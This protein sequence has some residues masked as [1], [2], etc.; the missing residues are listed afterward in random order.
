MGKPRDTKIAI[1]PSTTRKGTTLSTSAALDSPSVIDKLVSPPHASRA[2]TSAESENSHNIDNVSAVLDDSGSL[3]SFLDAT[4][5]KSRQIE[6][7]ETPNAA[8]PVNSPES[9]EYSSDDLDEDYVE[10]DND[11]I[12]KCKATTDARKIKKLLAEHAVRY[13]PSPD[14]KFAT[15]PINIR[16][17]DYDFSLDLSHIAIVEKTP[18]CGTE[19]ESAVEHLT[20]LSTLSGVFSDDVKM[21]TYFVAKIFPFSLKDDAKTWY[22]NLPPGSIKS[23]TDLRDVFFRKYFPASAQHAALQRIYNFDQEDGEKLPEAWARFCSLIRAQPDH[24]LEKHDLLDIFYSGLTIESRAYLDSCAG[25]VFRKRTPDDAEE[26]LAKI[27]RNHDD[28]STPEP[29]P[30]PIV[31]KRG[32]I[33]LNDEDMREAKKSLKE[34]GIKPEDVKNLPP[35]ED[36]CETIPPSSMIEDPLYPEGHP[37][38]VEQDSQPI[39]TSAPSKKK[40]KKHKNVVESSEPVNDPNSISISDAETESGNEHE[41]DN[42]KNDTP[43]KEEIEKEPEK[44]AKN[45]KYTKED[46]ITEKHGNER[47]PWVQKQMPFP[48]KKLKS[49]EEEHYNKFCDWMKP[50][51]LQIPLTDAIKL[52]PY[53]KYMKDIVTNKRKVPNEEISTMLANYSFN[54]KIPKKLGDPGIPTIPC[55]IKNNYVRTALCDLGAGVSVMPFSLYKR[56]DLDKL[57][58]TDISLQM[59][60]KSTAIPVGLCENVPVQVTQHCLI[61]TDFVVLEM[62]EDDNMSIILGR[63]FLNTAGAVIDCNKGM[64]TF[65]VDDKEHTVYFP[66]RIDKKGK[67]KKFKFGELFKKAT[68]S[69]GRPSRASTQIR[70]SYNEDVI[71]PSFAPE[72]DHGAPNASSFPCYEFLTNAG[73]L[74]DFFTLVNRA[75][76][77]TYVGD[78]RGQYYR[79]TK[80]FVES[81]KFH[82]TEYE[83]TVAFKIYDIPVTMKLEE[84]CFALGI[85]PV[86]TARRI[87]DNPR[88]LLEL[89]RGITGDDCRTIQRGKIRNIQLPAIK[90]FAYYVGTSILGRENT[91]NI[92]S[93]HLA[94]LNVA[95]TGETPY[96]L[97]SLIA[98]RLSSRGPIFGGTIA[99]RILTHLDIPLDSNDVPLTPRKLDI[100]AMKSHHFVTTNSTIDNIVYKMLFADGNEKEIPLPQQGLFNIDRQ[101]WSLT[102]EVVEEHMKIQE[103]HQQHDSE[104]AEPSYDYTVTYPDV[105]S[106]TYMEPGRSSSYYEDTTSWGPWE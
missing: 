68:T 16:D 86:G 106:S 99:S 3:G 78:E 62:P 5:A 97:G 77:A 12:E 59:A 79:L 84:F 8:T 6:N 66:K 26:L 73:L 91:S 105:S 11:F 34:K 36:I 69:T 56:L 35:I 63:P 102:K 29:T 33:K 93:Y 104:N 70:R 40:K 71:A 17:K 103:F 2:G 80:I 42:D 54:G 18:F 55:S 85:A 100:A 32:M 4:I 23:P 10:L 98:R 41:E 72:E 49:K 1:L 15:S 20:E 76:L 13:T 44:H 74:D 47:E 46:F 24:D 22:N 101:S 25:C 7:T 27:G 75:G 31:K 48:A 61:L 45:K 43:D 92:S 87:D 95:L 19:K 50:L 58:P 88:D 90:Y 89:Y 81:F 30:T 82:N 28:W 64:V 37:K 51:F 52:P 14:P 9:V 67:M 94:F 83:P 53:S 38:R 60:D 57:I 96:H 21:R 65:N 39:K